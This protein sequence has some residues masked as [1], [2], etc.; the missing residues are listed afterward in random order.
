MSR[1]CCLILLLLLN[2]L[3]IW[4]CSSDSLESSEYAY[5]SESIE[6]NSG[7]IVRT[8]IDQ[9]V[10]TPADRVRVEIQLNWNASFSVSLNDPLWEQSGWSVVETHVAPVV[11]E[12][13]VFRET[14]YVTLEPF[15]AGEYTIPT[16]TVVVDSNETDQHFELTTSPVSIIVESV[17]ESTDT[18]ELDPLIPFYSPAQTSTADS[19]HPILI[20]S[21]VAAIVFAIVIFILFKKPSSPTDPDPS[22][23]ELLNQIAKDDTVPTGDAYQKLHSAFSQLDHRLQM[24]SE[25]QS[26]IQHCERARFAQTSARADSNSEGLTPQQIATHTLSLLGPSDGGLE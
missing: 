22:P 11:Y 10:I 21:L 6:P 23:Y 1:I 4:G 24:T 15:L 3:S 9:V 20:S 14:H 8:I 16:S 13:D 18:G 19:T 7:V 26:F 12:D 5:E 2:L 25:I 17:L